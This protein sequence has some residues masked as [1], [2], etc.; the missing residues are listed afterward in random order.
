MS[1]SASVQAV[2]NPYG[3]SAP[4]PA[5]GGDL[6]ASIAVEGQRAIQEVKVQAEM[7]L[8]SPRDE[9]RCADAVLKACQ[10]PKFAEG[11]TYVY[12][13][14]GT[15]IVGPSIRMAEMIAANWRH[16]IAGWRVLRET[17]TFAEVEAYCWDMQANSRNAKSVTV[18]YIRSTK[19]GNYAVTDPR[20]KYEMLA[21]RAQRVLRGCILSLVPDDVISMAM[22]QVD[23]TLRA[24]ADVSTE[25]IKNMVQAFHDEH[26]VTRDQIE[27]RLGHNVEAIKPAQMIALKRIYQSL[28]DGMSEISTWFEVEAPATPDEEP[29]T[30][31]RTEQ[32]KA[33]LST[34]KRQ[35]AS[36]TNTPK[37]GKPDDQTSTK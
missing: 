24:S 9:R 29:A 2:K 33:A 35:A 34:S 3:D 11:A 13:R 8:I 14:G 17:E 26:G 7:A 1:D 10:R 4:V 32:A 16:M 37:D 25:S 18:P 5:N 27:K 23:E 21:N 6:S 15:D 22:E 20:D 31:T 30:Q 28:R 36:S 12:T 19:K